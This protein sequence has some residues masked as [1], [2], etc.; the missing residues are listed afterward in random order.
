MIV[1]S[2][3]DFSMAVTFECR[4]KERAEE[5]DRSQASDMSIRSDHRW[6]KEKLHI[7]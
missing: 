3:P 2:Y 4:Q 1:G 7:H 5:E 6:I